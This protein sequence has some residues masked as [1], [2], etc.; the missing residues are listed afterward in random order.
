MHC[1]SW[2]YLSKVVRTC[3]PV[4][5]AVKCVLSGHSKIDKTS[6]SKTNGRL[7]KVVSIAACS[8]G[9]FCNTFDLHYEKIGLENRFLDFFLSDRLRQ[10]LLYYNSKLYD[11]NVM[12]TS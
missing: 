3:K 2:V 10:V 4:I 11:F 5:C 8:L 9:T 1:K 12:T 6:V 7:M